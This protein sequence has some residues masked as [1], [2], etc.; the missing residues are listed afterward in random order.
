MDKGGATLPFTGQVAWVG[1]DCI[2]TWLPLRRRDATGPCR[3]RAPR[4]FGGPL[5]AHGL[6]RSETGFGTKSGPEGT[7]SARPT[8]IAFEEVLQR[9]AGDRPARGSVADSGRLHP[10][11]RS[12][13]IICSAC[14]L[15]VVGCRIAQGTLY[16]TPLCKPNELR[17]KQNYLYA[18]D[19]LFHLR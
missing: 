19:S 13:L 9:E 3:C 1:D 7:I 12:V 6:L 17:R 5:S 11:S 15:G 18:L 8:R 4:R 10:G 2:V 14:P 16:N